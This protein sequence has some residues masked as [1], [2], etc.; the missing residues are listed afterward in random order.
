MISSGCLA[1]CGPWDESYFLYSEETEFALR[2]RDRGHLTWF[3]PDAEA[4]HLGGESGVSPAL[5]SLLTVNRVR[6]YRRR[7]TIAAGA[8]FWSVVM[9]RES[10]RA[11]LGK[12]RSRRAVVALTRPSRLHTWFPTMSGPPRG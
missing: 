1:A 11:A 9:L 6:L 3:V 12:A 4:T 2:A 7:H 8:A 10:A 5:W